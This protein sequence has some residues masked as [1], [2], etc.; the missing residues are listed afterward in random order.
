MKEIR[1]VKFLVL[2]NGGVPAALLGFDAFRGQLG[3]NPV[4]FAIRTTGLLSLIFLL[5]S[6]TTTPVGRITGWTWL[7]QVRRTLG[8]YAFFH[9]LAHFAIFFVW[10][11]ALSVGSTLSEMLV[12]PYLTVGITGLLLMVPLAVTS[13]NRMIKRLGG[14]R[15]KRLHRLAYVAA[16]AGA[17]HYYMLVKADVRQPIAFAIVLTV[18]LGYRAAAYFAKRRA[19]HNRANSTPACLQATRPVPQHARD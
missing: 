17:L 1:F 6:L 7:T 2:L 12:R 16:I 9:A 10:D 19:A 5:L 4:N 8:L 18:L 3:A 14:A 13:T 15:W 11:R